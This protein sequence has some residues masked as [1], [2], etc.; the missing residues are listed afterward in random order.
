MTA[1]LRVGGEERTVVGE[2]NGAVDALAAVMREN[3]GVEMQI[4]D[5]EE[6]AIK[7][8]PGSDA[9][10]I[11]FVPI[12]FPGRE[13]VWGVGMDNDTTTANLRAVI[14]AVNRSL[15]RL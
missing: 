14:S 12:H 4:L 3:F 6:H 1:T 10:A 5:L 8:K 15:A 13:P 9:P 11:A 2:G 7:G